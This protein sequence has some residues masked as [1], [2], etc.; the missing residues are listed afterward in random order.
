MT[1]NKNEIITGLDNEDAITVCYGYSTTSATSA[2]LVKV[3][4]YLLCVYHITQP[5][6]LLVHGLSRFQSI[7]FVYTTL[8]RFQCI[9]FV[10]TTLFIGILV[11]VTEGSWNKL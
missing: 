11:Y 9:Y 5:L 8:S 7:Y 1:F 4:V 10:Y 6:L 3:S 2:W